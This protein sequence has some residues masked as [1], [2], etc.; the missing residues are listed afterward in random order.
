MWLGATPTFD[1]AGVPEGQGGQCPPPQILSNKRKEGRSSKKQ[2]LPPPPI[3]GPSDAPGVLLPGPLLLLKT[4]LQNWVHNQ[5]RATDSTA[6]L[7]F[8]LISV[9]VNFL[10]KK[11]PNL[12]K[13]VCQ[14]IPIFFIFWVAIFWWPF[15]KKTWEGTPILLKYAMLN[16]RYSFPMLCCKCI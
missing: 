14:K 12:E 6:A 11:C 16:R 2:L 3:F 9:Y 7:L 8:R 15:E 5:I 4:S 10:R 13:Q 1:S